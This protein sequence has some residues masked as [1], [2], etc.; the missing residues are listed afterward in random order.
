MIKNI[1]YYPLVHPSKRY[2]DIKNSIINNT[3]KVDFL[4]SDIYRADFILVLGGDWYML[5]IIKK[6]A[7]YNKPFIGINC[8]TLWFLMNNISDIDRLP[9]SIDEW[10]LRTAKFIKAKV[11]FED[12]S[13]KIWYAAN[14]ICIWN[15]IFDYY[16]ISVSAQNTDKLDIKWTWVVIAN[17]FGST[18]YRLSLWWPL[19]PT[20]SDLIGIIWVWSLPFR[21][22]LYKPQTVDIIIDGKSKCKSAFDWYSLI[23]E[24]IKSLQILPS[25]KTYSIWFLHTNPI[26]T[27]RVLMAEAK[28]WY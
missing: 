19:I 13:S 18:S 24:D 20:S 3:D 21:F 6:Y 23:Y 15:S 12:G 25:D 22:R 11:V 7:D 4:T 28:I 8:G 1:V 27:K 17:N 9:K 2:M 5:E 10:N 16:N 26:E 14:D